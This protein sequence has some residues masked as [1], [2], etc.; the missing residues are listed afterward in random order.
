MFTDKVNKLRHPVI[1]RAAF[2]V[3]NKPNAIAKL[4]FLNKIYAPIVLTFNQDDDSTRL[5]GGKTLYLVGF[6]GRNQIGNPNSAKKIVN[7]VYAN[8]SNRFKYIEALKKEEFETKYNDSWL[9]NSS[10][11]LKKAIALKEKGEE[12]FVLKFDEKY[13]IE[14]F[15]KNTFKIKQKLKE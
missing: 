5:F 8:T 3:F 9:T 6:E 15:K 14:Q 11:D 4:L 2:K 12:T 10:F 1:M 7:L 13:L